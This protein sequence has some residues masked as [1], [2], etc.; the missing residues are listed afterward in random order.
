M[1]QQQ[2]CDQ[3]LGPSDIRY[4]STGWENRQDACIYFDFHKLLFCSDTAVGP[5]SMV[6]A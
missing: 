2:I 5:L 3:A 4:R 1:L 6:Y